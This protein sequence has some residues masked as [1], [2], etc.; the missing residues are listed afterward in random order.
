MTPA[1]NADLLTRTTLQVD[2][3]FAGRSLEQMISALQRVPGVL[4]AEVNAA[5]AG[6]IV[7]HDAAVPAASLIAA[8]QN[9]G[10]HVR[11]VH[12]TRA[13]NLAG[14]VGAPLHSL[15]NRQLLLV[16][17]VAFVISSIVDLLIPNLAQKHGILIV[18][19]SSLWAFYLATSL[20]RRRRS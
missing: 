18:L 19:T 20:L 12:D 16:A 13:T 9:V 1:T 2:G 17:A 3:G 8:A 15:G 7:A 6:A 4:F 5:N 11:V 10:V 14:S